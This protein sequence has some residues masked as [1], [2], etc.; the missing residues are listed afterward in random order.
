[1]HQQGKPFIET[2]SFG[3]GDASGELLIRIHDGG[4]DGQFPRASSAHVKLNDTF[5]ATPH[6]FNRQTGLVERSV[7]LAAGNTLSVKLEGAP[8]SGL[9]VEIYGFDHDA[10][11]ITAQLP[12]RAAG[13]GAVPWARPPPEW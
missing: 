3:V 6:N 13:G 12:G 11:T 5:V 1:M 2:R 7:R 8:G 4:R 10:P 9:A